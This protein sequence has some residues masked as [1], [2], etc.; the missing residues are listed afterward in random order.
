MAAINEVFHRVSFAAQKL[1]Q[2][3]VAHHH[4]VIEVV[5]GDHNSIDSAL[6]GPQAD[7][8][9]FFCGKRVNSWNHIELDC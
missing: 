3:L 7:L 4:F 8:W 2:H 9:A 6:P 5:P 1:V